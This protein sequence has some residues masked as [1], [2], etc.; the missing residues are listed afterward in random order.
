V[1]EGAYWHY[2]GNITQT[3]KTAKGPA[4]LRYLRGMV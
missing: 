1:R 3:W 4:K 2:D